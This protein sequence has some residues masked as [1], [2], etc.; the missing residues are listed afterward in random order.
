MLTHYLSNGL[1]M[2][3]M[4]VNKSDIVIRIKTIAIKEELCYSENVKK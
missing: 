3:M 1:L 2:D 4:S